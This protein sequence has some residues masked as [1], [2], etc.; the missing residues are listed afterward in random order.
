MGFNYAKEK[1]RFDAEWLELAEEYRAAGF[2]EA[3]IQA[4]REFDWDVFRQRRT[5]ENRTQDLPSEAFDSADDVCSNLFKKYSTLTSGFDESEFS[6]RYDWI[7]S[8]DNPVLAEK[9][10]KLNDA[11]K[12]LLTLVAF[13]GYSQTEIAALQG[14]SKVVVCKKIKRIKK[15]IF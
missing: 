2:D 9:L 5:Y 7:E 14:C 8:I 10:K 4:M 6:G 11:D 12:E 15:I 1:L 13:D 3:G